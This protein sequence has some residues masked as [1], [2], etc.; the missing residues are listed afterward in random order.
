MTVSHDQQKL[1]ETSINLLEKYVLDYFY[2]PFQN[3]IYTDPR[4]LFGAVSQSCLRCCLPS[5]SPHFAQIKT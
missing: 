2:S 1:Y 3:H 4:C 5:C